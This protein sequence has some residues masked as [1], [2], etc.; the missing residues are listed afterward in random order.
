[1][2]G[3]E[4]QNQVKAALAEFVPSELLVSEWSVRRGAQ[5]IFGIG[6]SYSPRLDVAIGPFN[7]TF[8]N[9]RD[10]ARAIMEANGAL[11]R[12]LLDAVARQNPH[13]YENSNPRC[14][15]GIEIEDETS[16]KHIL[17]G[18]TNVSMLGRLGIVIGPSE[19]IAKI[20]RIHAYVW[21]L[22]EVEKA[23]L[24]MFGNVGCFEIEEFLYLL[25][26]ARETSVHEAEARLWTKNQF[27]P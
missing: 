6:D 14:L 22:K 13:F 9:R 4:I 20:R 8:Q 12:V 19:N 5:D 27:E 11:I 1:M 15:V 3:I 16:S 26:L 24:D 7:P 23:P 18:I 2:T 21:K 17:G 25:G 10:H